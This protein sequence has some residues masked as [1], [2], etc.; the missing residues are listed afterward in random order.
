M[1]KRGRP[2]K[3]RAG[4]VAGSEAGGRE[5][6]A[7]GVTAGVWGR[8]RLEGRRWRRE[9]EAEAGAKLEGGPAAPPAVRPAPLAQFCLAGSKVSQARPEQ[10][11][12]S[13]A[14]VFPSQD[15]K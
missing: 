7:A 9:R 14:F 8:G 5:R 6:L 13:P 11:L 4:E 1:R 15:G 2:R 3:S 10:L 12:L